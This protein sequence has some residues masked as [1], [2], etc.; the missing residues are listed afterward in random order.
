LTVSSDPHDVRTDPRRFR[1][2]KALTS[3]AYALPILVD[4]TAGTSCPSLQQSEAA[5]PRCFLVILPPGCRKSRSNNSGPRPVAR[6]IF[7]AVSAG[8]RSLCLCRS[9]APACD[10]TSSAILAQPHT[11][12][13]LCL[14]PGLREAGNQSPR[15]A[16]SL[17]YE[18][19]HETRERQ[20]LPL[21]TQPPVSI[22][23]A[24][25]NCGGRKPGNLSEKQDA[26]RRQ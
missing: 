10:A 6:L 21:E 9:R 26:P 24:R 7:F 4:K 11:G 8:R 19:T 14:S 12:S 23:A 16:S 15:A 13:F 22:Y 5:V 3:A 18:V 2:P 17:P 20:L 25:V 1:A